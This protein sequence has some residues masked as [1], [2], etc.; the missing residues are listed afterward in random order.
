MTPLLLIVLSGAS[1]QAR[2]GDKLRRRHRDAPARFT[3]PPTSLELAET[4]VLDAMAQAG[5]LGRYSATG[6]EPFEALLASLDSPS[7]VDSADATAAVRAAAEALDAAAGCVVV[8]WRQIEHAAAAGQDAKVA[9]IAEADDLLVGPLAALALD[10]AARL[11]VT[12]DRGTEPGSAEPYDGPQPLLRW[13]ASIG[14]E[15]GPG[16]GELTDDD[17]PVLAMPKRR[18]TRDAAS[19]RRFTERWVAPLPAEAAGYAD[20][21]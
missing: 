21:S 7:V 20:E 12:V 18:A 19:G 8:R 10:H 1:E 14:D 13:Y 3:E 9:A 11:V 2:A 17:L 5:V 6:A 16:D 4:P 15:D